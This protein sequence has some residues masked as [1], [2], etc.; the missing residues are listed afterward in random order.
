MDVCCISYPMLHNK[1]PQKS[2]TKNHTHLLSYS[3]HGAGVCM[4]QLALCLMVSQRPQPSWRPAPQSSEPDRGQICVQA[5]SRACS[6]D[7]VPDGLL[8]CRPGF[9][10]GCW[11]E[12][13]LRS[14]LFGPLSGAVYNIGSWL[15]SESKRVS[16]MKT[17]VFL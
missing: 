3:V 10:T 15:H 14:L 17:M 12:A 11:P 1:L 7:L 16:T 9:L 5:H 2:A 13:P 4:A 8:D 6:Q